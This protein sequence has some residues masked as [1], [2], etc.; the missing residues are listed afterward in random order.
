[1]DNRRAFHA[2]LAAGLAAAVVPLAAQSASQARNAPYH[3]PRTAWGAPDI[4]GDYTNKDEANTPLERPADLAGKAV[5]SFDAADLAELAQER[6]VQARKIAGGIG[7]AE[8]G[9]GPTHWYDNLAA[10][11][12]RPWFII[13]PPDG[14]LPAM[15]PQALKREAAVAALNNARDGDG[16]ADSP[17]DRSMYDRCITRGIPGSMMPAIYG[18]SYQI[19]QTPDTIAIRYEMIHETRII[20]LDG[21]PH[22]PADIHQLLGDPRGHWDGDALVVET[23]NFTN[24]THFGYN[25]RYNSEKQ[26][27]TER[28][29]PI[30]PGKLDWQVTID[31]P[32]VWTRPFTF[33]MTLTRDA[34]QPIYEYACH[35]G[36]Y[37]LRD[38]LM[39]ARAEDRK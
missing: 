38:I 20:P 29:T 1:M 14:H 24:R 13:D 28:F 10:K 17:E 27:I 30:A 2:L 22:I 23:T 39:G 7:G 25:N 18:N 35:E 34:S 15:T 12:S 32:D 21:R 26:K 31:D 11:G 19:V 5:S 6:S 3:A 33:A 9:A 36:N 16:R 37:G 8:T 4:H